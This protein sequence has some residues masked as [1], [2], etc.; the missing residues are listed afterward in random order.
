MIYLN[1][2]VNN[3][4]YNLS[5]QNPYLPKVAVAPMLDW[6]DRHCRFFHR[7]LTS[8][9][10]L[11][12]EM[13]VADA[14]IHGPR[15]RLLA[16][17]S[18]EKP[19]AVQLGGSD[20]TKLTE[21]AKI[22]ADYGY[23]EIN[24]NLGCPSEKVQ[25]GQFG[26]SLMQQPIHVG[27][28]VAALKKAVN[29]PITVKCRIGID[30]HP[31]P[32]LLNTIGDIMVDNGVDALWIHARKAWLNGL[33]PKENREVPSLE[34]DVVYNFKLRHPNLFVGING[35]IE[36]V[37]QITEHLNNVDA[38]MIGRK[39]YKYPRLLTKMDNSIYNRNSKTV[40]YAEVIDIMVDYADRHIKNGGK[41]SHISMHMLDL[42]NGYEGAKNWRRILSNDARKEG[43]QADLIKMAFEQIDFSKNNIE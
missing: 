31:I 9:T 33:S 22:V 24:I 27:N 32:D 40:N 34:Y 35:G 26:A 2:L 8:Y 43:V 13:I 36:T 10:L 20:I 3:F 15:D 39:A 30:Q 38:V 19:L 11:F 37:E 23:N 6:T 7:Q 12:T 18:I 1:N 42:F 14:I 29:I 41:L 4:N 25:A 17:S 28:L 16:F 21:A 5:K